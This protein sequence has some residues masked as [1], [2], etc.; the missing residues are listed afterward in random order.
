[1]NAS[2]VKD[3]IEP[4]RAEYDWTSHGT[5]ANPGK[6]EGE[7]IAALYYYDCSMN[8]SGED[9]S[10]Y[11]VDGDICGP[12]EQLFDVDS[13]ER[14]ALNLS[15]GTFAV[16]LSESDQGFVSLTELTLKEYQDLRGAIDARDTEREQDEAEQ[17]GE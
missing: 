5:I 17:V 10:D 16:L 13:A 7:T 3:A 12:N 15:A 11:S 2:E 14:E 8:G 1:M 4:M 6:F 9:V